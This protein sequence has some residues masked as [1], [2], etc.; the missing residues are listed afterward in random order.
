MF[1]LKK[2]RNQTK[3]AVPAF[4]HAR[5]PRPPVIHVLFM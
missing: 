5:N 3:A 1:F 2:G 4:H